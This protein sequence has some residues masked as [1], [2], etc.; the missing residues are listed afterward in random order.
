MTER[1]KKVGGYEVGYGKPPRDT[2]FKPG[3]TGNRRGREKESKNLKTDLTEE[4]S[5]QITLREGGRAIRIS[6]R[7]A[8]VKSAITLAIKGDPRAQAKAFDLLL[9]LFGADDE[10]G[11][12]ANV[13]EEDEAIL[14]AYLNRKK[15]ELS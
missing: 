5:E 14:T 6:K 15:A 2:Q 8:L 9:K 4:L 13:T 1:H 12:T 10:P 7:R 3:Q 11:A